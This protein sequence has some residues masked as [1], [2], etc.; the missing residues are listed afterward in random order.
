MNLINN[1]FLKYSHNLLK[2]LDLSRKEPMQYQKKWFRYL[3]E[4][5]RGSAFGKEHGFDNI[6]TP[7]LNGQNSPEADFEIEYKNPTIG[8]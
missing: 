7:I 5:G 4:C 1:I 8:F 3:L 2:E 6:N